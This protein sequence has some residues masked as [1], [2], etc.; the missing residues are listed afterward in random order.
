MPRGDGKKNHSVN[1]ERS[2][3][4]QK[5]HKRQKAASASARDRWMKAKTRQLRY[6]QHGDVDHP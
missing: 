2:I 1:R 5:R 3:A 6:W 4:A